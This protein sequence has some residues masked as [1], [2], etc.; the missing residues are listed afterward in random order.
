MSWGCEQQ[1]LKKTKGKKKLN[2]NQK[3]KETKETKTMTTKKIFNKRMAV[4]LRRLGFKIVGTEVN[5]NYP[6][7]DVY[8]FEDTAELRK[9]MDNYRK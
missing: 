9:A 8:L 5:F 4:Y 6:E 3:S 2:Q 1:P 7:F